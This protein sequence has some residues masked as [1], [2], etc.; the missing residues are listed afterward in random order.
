MRSWS[1]H[2]QFA[3]KLYRTRRYQKFKLR[4]STKW[5]MQ[6][7][8][9]GHASFAE[10]LRQIISRAGSYPFLNSLISDISGRYNFVITHLFHNTEIRVPNIEH[11]QCQI[12][13]GVP[14]HN[15]SFGRN[16]INETISQHV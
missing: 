11:S 14:Y 1:A 7:D 16:K 12:N 15:S 10:P 3:K 9:H 6:A 5:H 4:V 13:P 2:A 8:R